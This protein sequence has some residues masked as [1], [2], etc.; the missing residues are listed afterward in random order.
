MNHLGALR[1]SAALLLVSE[2]LL[3][4]HGGTSS[5]HA[6]LVDAGLIPVT[7]TLPRSATE[8]SLGGVSV[9]DNGVEV[10]IRHRMSGSASVAV[11]ALV[12][13]NRRHAADW[14]QAKEDILH[15]LPQVNLDGRALVT[16]NVVRNAA[17]AFAKAGP[18]APWV[19]SHRTF[20]SAADWALARA[21]FRTSRRIML[22]VTDGDHRDPP[23]D[24][25]D[26]VSGIGADD[27]VRR[28][29]NEHAVLY[30]IRLGSGKIPSQLRTWAAASGGTARDLDTIDQ[31]PS[32]LQDIASELVAQIVLYVSPAVA[33][34]RLHKLVVRSATPELAVRATQTYQ[35]GAGQKK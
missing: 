20:W 29:R 35:S 8:H 14:F 32:A 5:R 33:D 28:L 11:T 26:G 24:T 1:V 3:G 4:Q 10:T 18:D 9:F 19:K 34:G 6:D 16:A 2:S 13:V 17:G 21:T 25:D 30:V 15:L 22:L 27:F 23:V 31:L 7:L 12:H